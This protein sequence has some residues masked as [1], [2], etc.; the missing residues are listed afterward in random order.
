[1]EFIRESSEEQWEPMETDSC[2]LHSNRLLCFCFALLWRLLALA[3]K[4][5]FHTPALFSKLI[6]AQE[7]SFRSALLCSCFLQKSTDIKRYR[8]I[9]EKMQNYLIQFSQITEN[10][11]NAFFP[12]ISSICDIII[13]VIHREKYNAHNVRFV[14][15]SVGSY[16]IRLS[17]CFRK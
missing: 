12:V 2:Y 17:L 5:I 9:F 16:T 10:F 1:M 11:W 6:A 13:G 3:N 14:A 4:F 8:W 7:A 15:G